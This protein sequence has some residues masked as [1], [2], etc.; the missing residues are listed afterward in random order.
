MIEI[1]KLKDWKAPK[2]WTEIQ[3]IDVH[4][5]LVESHSE[6]LFQDSQG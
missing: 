2:D 1:K 4:I 5:I 3:T 6:L